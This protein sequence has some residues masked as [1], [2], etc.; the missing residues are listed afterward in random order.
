MMRNAEMIGTGDFAE[1]TRLYAVERCLT[2]M[3]KIMD[4]FQDLMIAYSQFSLNAG[5]E[6]YRKMRMLQEFEEDED[7]ADIGAI[8][9]F[10]T[11]NVFE[12]S[13]KAVEND[14]SFENE[15]IENRGNSG[16]L[17][18]Y[19]AQDLVI[20]CG[21]KYLDGAMV[22]FKIDPEGEI[23][24]LEEDEIRNARIET[25]RMIRKIQLEEERPYVFALNKEEA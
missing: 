24:P 19:A 21:K 9:V 1:E 10:P 17:F 2:L 18:S 22:V 11:G 14:E 20:A 6:V 3:E 15:I 12:Y 16:L 5:E 25:M 7:D 13:L 4:D 8:V 23:L